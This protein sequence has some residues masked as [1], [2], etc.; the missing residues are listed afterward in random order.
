[1]PPSLQGTPSLLTVLQ[2]IEPDLVNAGHN[3]ALPDSAETLLTSLNELG[4]RQLV[5][6]VQWAK[7]LPGKV[8]WVPGGR[9]SP[10][11]LY[12]LSSSCQFPCGERNMSEMACECQEMQ[13]HT[14]FE[15]REENRAPVK[16]RKAILYPQ[17]C[18]AAIKLLKERWVGT[19]ESCQT[20]FGGGE[21]SLMSSKKI[22]KTGSLNSNH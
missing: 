17:K 8:I 22:K 12:G 16:L 9:P 11:P 4:E 14:C 5:A 20:V 7:A 18:R 15:G 1:M 2:T 10:R 13:G 3:D 21:K 19:R 6:V